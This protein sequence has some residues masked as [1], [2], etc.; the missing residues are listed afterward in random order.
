MVDAW[1]THGLLVTAAVLLVSTSGCVG[2]TPA[3]VP[4]SALDVGSGNGWTRNDDG[5]EEVSG[6]VLQ[7]QAQR[8]Y[9]DRAVDDEGFPGNLTVISIATLLSPDREDLKDRV[10][11]QLAEQARQSGLELDDQVRE[12]QRRVAD[13]ALSFFIVFNGTATEGDGLY[14]EGMRV[15]ILGEVFRCTGGPTVVATGSAQV[16]GTEQIGDV[17]TDRRYDPETWAEIVRD[18]EGTIEGFTG[19]GLVY[20]IACP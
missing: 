6:G 19:A 2:L 11:E 20:R 10:R 15:K 8:A 17:Q 12:G 9:H 18:P 4:G 3:E 7:K 16:E 1:P 13:G 5:F 14:T